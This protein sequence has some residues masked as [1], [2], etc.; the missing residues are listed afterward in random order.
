MFFA[1]TKD[2]DSPLI[3]LTGIL[4]NEP[5][6]LVEFDQ[7]I[8]VHDTVDGGASVWF[9]Q[10]ASGSKVK[11]FKF[12]NEG[13]EL[14]Q[15]WPPFGELTGYEAKKE[16]SIPIHCK[17]RGV[18]FILQR[19]DYSDVPED[20]LPSN[21]DPKTHKLTAT[22]CGC[23]SC[24]LQGGVDVFNWTYTDLKYITFNDS[25]KPFPASS[26]DLKKLVDE[27]DPALGTLKYYSSSEDVERYFCSTCS[28]CVFYA[29]TSRP[30]IID[31][32]LGVLG[33]SDG[34]R[35]EGFLSWSYGARMSYQE[36]GDGGWR[37][38]LFSKVVQ[39]AEEYRIAR[40]YPKN[41][42][43]ISKDENGGRSPE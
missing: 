40:G 18:E 2:T 10:N 28:A 11:S 20:Q 24:R 14:P 31:V 32:A 38:K 36:D 26:Y 27:N 39:S 13:E 3:A 5:V 41:S 8:F 42:K 34:A 33:A 25:D 1:N 12:N 21:I 37:E 9:Q 22:F 7:Q 30:T 4:T 35:A 16:G 19:G 23:D 43:R 15:D 29:T 17:C 6:D